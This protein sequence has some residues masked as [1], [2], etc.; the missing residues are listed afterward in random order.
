MTRSGRNPL[1]LKGLRR[2]TSIR[3]VGSAS[4][5]GSFTL[6]RREAR[7]Q[8][9]T[10]NRPRRGLSTPSSTALSYLDPGASPTTTNARRLLGHRTRGLAAPGNDGLLRLITR[11]NP[12]SEPVTTID[13][14]SRLRG[15]DSSRSSAIRTPA[16]RHLSTMARCQ[17]TVNQSTTTAAIVAPTP[18]T[19]A[20]C[21]TRAPRW[22][23]IH[24]TRW[25]ARTAIG[26]W[27][28]DRRHQDTP[29]LL[30]FRLVQGFSRQPTSVGGQ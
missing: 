21:S 30:L 19:A 22:L 15:I 12:G 2:P 8:A 29:Q 10:P 9:P 7:R 25:P 28:V 18:S 27:R 14:P 17:S 6:S 13:K 24:R 20:S 3:S 16:A 23:P 26:P 5:R 11:R 1:L 4:S